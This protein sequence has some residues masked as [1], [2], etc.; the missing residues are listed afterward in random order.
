MNKKGSLELSVNAI[1]ILIIAL[2]VMG[3]VIGFAVTRFR[4]LSN[5][6]QISEE[7]PEPNSQQPITLPGGRS[8]LSL[9][10]KDVAVMEIKVY[11]P[12]TE[13]LCASGK[14]CTALKCKDVFVENNG[15]CTTAGCTDIIE[16]TGNDDITA[17]FNDGKGLNHCSG[18]LSSVTRCEDLKVPDDYYDFSDIDW[19]DFDENY[20]KEYCNHYQG[21]E[22]VSGDNCKEKDNLEVLSCSPSGLIYE[23]QVAPGSI[24]AA[25][26]TKSIPVRLFIDP[27]T[28]VGKYACNLKLNEDISRTVFL[29]IQ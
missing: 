19:E 17:F 14:I 27:S 9:S 7:T 1:V 5:E 12:G 29:K 6:I 10:K 28:Q 4:S 2:A 15:D 20:K 21:C 11:N 16:I 26:Q 23:W 25:G 3:L 18:S 13:S 22:W 8:E 24:I